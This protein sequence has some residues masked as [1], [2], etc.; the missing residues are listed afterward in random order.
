[1]TTRF[2]RRMALA[3]LGATLLARPAVAITAPDAKAKLP[4]RAPLP[5]PDQVA[6]LDWDD[7]LPERE[8]GQDF[9]DVAPAHDYLG[10]G[11]PG[12]QQSGSSEVRKELDG[13]RVKVPGFIVPLSLAANGIVKEFFL[14]PF[15]GACI[16]VP[17]PPPNQIVYG[18]SEAGLRPKTVYEPYWITGRLATKSKGSRLGIA[19]YSLEVEKFERYEY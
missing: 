7:L 19:S 16:H 6:T 1:M 15:F 3:L 12:V 17:P 11:G 9:Q 4:P 10:E 5:P 2:D 13:H 8:R 14:V 18:R